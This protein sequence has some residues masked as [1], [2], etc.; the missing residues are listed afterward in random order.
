MEDRINEVVLALKSEPSLFRSFADSD[1]E[2]IAPYF[3]SRQYP[4]GATLFEEGDAGDFIAVIRSGEVEVKKQTEFAGRWVILAQL[5]K[6]SIL[7]ELAMFDS[8]PRSATV[9]ILEDSELLV[10][11]RD[12]LELFFQEH[13]QLGV[14]LLKG[15][16]R[17]LSLRLRKS[18]E[19]L[20][21]IF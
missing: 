15:I 10:L 21:L 1:L 14:R 3:E 13:P 19:R 12:N 16:C 17:I 6:G 18:A 11:T 5:G 4:S 9:L 2:V 8:H 7:G 20:T